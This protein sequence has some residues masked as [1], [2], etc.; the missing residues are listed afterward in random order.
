MPD[1]IDLI[2]LLAIL[3]RSVI[4][5]L[6][7]PSREDEIIVS[8]YVGF[9][10]IHCHLLPNIDDGAQGVNEALSMATLAVEESI[11]TVVVTPHQLGNYAHNSGQAIRDKTVEFRQLMAEH[12]VPLKILPGADVRIEDGVLDKL[13]CGEVLTLGDHGK[14]VLLELPHELY[15]SL[16]GLLRGL[17]SLGMVGILSHPERNQGLLSCRGPVE[18]L[19]DAGCL[20]QVT[21]GSLTGVFG[22]ASQKLA[23]WALRKGLVHFVSTDAHGACSRRPL[24]KECYHRVVE[25]TDEETAQALFSKNPRRVSCGQAV[26]SGRRAIVSPVTPN[27][28]GFGK[29]LGVLR[30]SM[31]A[32]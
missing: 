20:M 22:S 32:R 14:H 12:Q 18:R 2:P 30:G 4:R 8:R 24:L 23:E 19:V 29:A 21:A 6:S 7:S 11:E 27:W 28:Y 9:V 25:L 17:R 16:E 3:R 26:P 10:D 5:Q 1:S 13:A 15:F 31:L